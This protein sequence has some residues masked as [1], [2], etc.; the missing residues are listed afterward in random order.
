MVGTYAP[1][2]PES[3]RNIILKSQ[4]HNEL[5]NQGGVRV[6]ANDSATSLRKLWDQGVGPE[7]GERHNTFNGGNYGI[8]GESGQGE[9]LHMG[10]I[11]I[12]YPDDSPY[13]WLFAKGGR[14]GGFLTSIR[15]WLRLV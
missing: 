4:L 15:H 9:R 1:A 13:L 3:K 14:G 11:H 6:G 8:K 7:G 2:E 12:R 10:T 5:W